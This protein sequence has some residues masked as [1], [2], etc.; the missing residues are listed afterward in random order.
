M[1]DESAFLLPAQDH[2][3]GPAAAPARQ[4]PAI[5]HLPLFRRGTLVSYQDQTCTV[6][7]VVVSRYDLQVYLREVGQPVAA[8]KLQLPPTRLELR[9]Q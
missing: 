7:H 8:E 4:D 5:V 9:R 2:T 3:A 6:S 1:K